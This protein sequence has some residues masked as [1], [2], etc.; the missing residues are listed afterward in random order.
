MGLLEIIGLKKKKANTIISDRIKK[1]KT[2]T[3]QIRFYIGGDYQ[4][5]KHHAIEAY[6]RYSHE[7]NVKNPVNAH[8]IGIDYVFE[9]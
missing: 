8:T 6:Y 5:A 7:M 4:I 1:E 9:F 2:E 3:E